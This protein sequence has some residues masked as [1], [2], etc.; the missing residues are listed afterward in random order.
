MD[1]MQQLGRRQVTQGF[2]Q[3]Q[4]QIGRA[5]KC[6]FKR[7]QFTRAHLSERNA[8]S[9]ALDVTGAFELFS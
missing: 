9:D 5:E 7:Y 1:V 3:V 4:R 6:I 8:R 2:L